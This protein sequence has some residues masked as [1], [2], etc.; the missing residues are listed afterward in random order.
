MLPLQL[1]HKRDM[2]AGILSVCPSVTQ[3]CPAD[4]T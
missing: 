4:L 2:T 1:A 3:Q